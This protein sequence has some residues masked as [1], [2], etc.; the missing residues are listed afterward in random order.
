[1]TFLGNQNDK[2]INN[3]ENLT[4]IGLKIATMT[5]LNSVISNEVKIFKNLNIKISHIMNTYV[6]KFI[7]L[8]IEERY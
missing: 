3:N 5:F 7:A 6:S 1:M 8:T 2:F 4:K